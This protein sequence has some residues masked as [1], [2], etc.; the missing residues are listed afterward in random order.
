MEPFR[1][2]L[3]RWLGSPNY[4]PA[5]AGHDMSPPSWV[6]LHTMV[7]TLGA[8]NSRFQVEREMASAHYGVG[9]DGRLYQWVN[10]RDAAWTNG[11]T[12]RG[13]VGDNL[14]SI[15]IEHEDGGDFDGPRTPE[16]YAAS[17]MLVADI[18]ERYAIPCDRDHVIGHRECDYAST[19][20]PDAL[21]LD[22]IVRDAWSIL[23]PGADPELA[24]AAW[25]WCASG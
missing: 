13:G 9:L 25:W 20:C 19:R 11:A 8:A 5:R 12:G 23:N 2:P 4:T 16:L 6:V 17:A 24:G 14:D 15:T 21:D 3:A 10:E 7:G 1:N 18:C 22:R